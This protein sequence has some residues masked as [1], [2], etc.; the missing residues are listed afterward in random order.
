MSLTT[1]WGSGFS[2]QSFGEKARDL[3]TFF[4][5]IR[6]W[7]CFSMAFLIV[8]TMLVVLL[9]FTLI[10]ELSW[11]IILL[12]TRFGVLRRVAPPKVICPERGWF[13]FMLSAWEFPLEDGLGLAGSAMLWVSLS[14]SMLWGKISEDS[15]LLTETVPPTDTMFED[16][17]CSICFV[18]RPLLL[19]L[20]SDCEEL[21]FL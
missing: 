11:F 13:A 16:L 4:S 19:R 5:A 20:S 6:A 14:S 8:L 17:K 21:E 7:F 1:S 3:S 18:W 12:W 9:L 2:R 15:S 10:S